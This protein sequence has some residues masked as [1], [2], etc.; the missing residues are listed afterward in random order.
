MENILQTF[1][2]IVII[3][4]KNS[5]KN[6]FLKIKKKNKKGRIRTY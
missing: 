5:R 1:Q 2:I 3:N 4:E 6:I